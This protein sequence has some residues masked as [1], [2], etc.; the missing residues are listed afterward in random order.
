MKQLMVRVLL[1]LFTFSLGVGLDRLLTLNPKHIEKTPPVL[2]DE[3]KSLVH[4][5]SHFVFRGTPVRAKPTLIFDYDTEK[6]WPEGSYAI[7]G[8]RPKGFSKD[9]YF[10]IEIW[11]GDDTDQHVWFS[12]L[13][14][15]GN[16]DVTASFALVTEKRLIF[17]TQPSSDGFVYR[18]DGEFLR[19]GAIY[20]APE[21][22][23]VLKGT[24]TT[25]KD[26][27][28]VAEWPMRFAVVHD[29]C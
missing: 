25:S 19:R 26:N 10:F 21:G 16:T 1:A 13:D 14:D 3:T 7:I 15:R 12:I 18:F 23:A 2:S 9:D 20:D 27:R 17:V 28:T 22:K 24:L 4:A 8:K 29:G 11:R 6:F 5:T